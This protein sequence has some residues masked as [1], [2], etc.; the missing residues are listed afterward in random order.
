MRFPIRRSAAKWMFLLAV[1]AGVGVAEEPLAP[2]TPLATNAQ[3]VSAP[4]STDL[5]KLASAENALE[6]GFSSAAAGTYQKLLEAAS[7][8]GA[9]H[10]QLVIGLT[11]AYMDLGQI[12]DAS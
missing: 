10:N 5:S 1:T 4:S 12:N 11:R 7:L 8:A 9:Y 2:A 3:E 6:L